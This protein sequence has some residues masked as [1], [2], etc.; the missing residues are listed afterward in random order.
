MCAIPLSQKNEYVTSIVDKVLKQRIQYLLESATVY[1]QSLEQ[2]CAKLLQLIRP[3]NLDKLIALMAKYQ[4]NTA[5]F[6]DK[7]VVESASRR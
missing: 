7:D 1:H 2:S 4:G 3:V 6:A 5:K